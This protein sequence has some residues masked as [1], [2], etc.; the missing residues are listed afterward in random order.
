MAIRSR[1]FVGIAEGIKSHELS[2]KSK[3][4]SLKGT[5]SDLSSRRFGLN[6]EISSLEAE[7]AA[8][9]EDTDE[10]DEPNYALID[11]IESQIASA[12][13]ELSEVEN[14][15][16]DANS[17]LSQS[18]MEL[19]A[20][21]EEKAQ[22]LFE[23]QERARKTSQNI[24]T[25]GGMYG[26]YMGV[27]NTLQNSMQTSL[28]SL[29]QAASILDGSVDGSS[30]GGAGGGQGRTASG[31]G[32][33]MPSDLS[34]SALSAF[35]GGGA[36]SSFSGGSSLSNFST[37]H[38]SG[39]TPASS[40]NFGSSQSVNP[41]KTIN[42][43]SDQTESSYASAAFSESEFIEP[44]SNQASK[45]QSSQESGDLSNPFNPFS[46]WGQSKK[47]TNTTI[48]EFSGLS[49]DKNSLYGD[50]YFVK[51]NNYEAFCEYTK[52]IGQYNQINCNETKSIS[53]KDIEGIYLNDS[54]AHDAHFFWNRG[55]KY[56]MDSESFFMKVASYIPEFQ[57]R[58]NN[59]ESIDSIISN[60]NMRTCYELYFQKPIEVY[61]V[62][63]FYEYAGSG[64]HR[65]MAA[66]KLGI[67]IPV[68]VVARYERKDIASAPPRNIFSDSR[69]YGYIVDK[70]TVSNVTYRPIR[71]NT[72]HRSTADIVSRLSGGD[73]TQGS[74]S[75]LA[76]AYAGNKAGYD[77]LDFRDG[78]SRDFFSSRKSI[79]EI[80]NL[81]NV[82]SSI[83]YGVNDIENARTQLRKI[84]PEKEYYFAI[85][86]HAAIIRKHQDHFE[87]LE[88]QHPST[89]N[90]WHTLDANAL[91]AR[92]GCKRERD[93]ESSSYLIDV[94]T[95][96][97]NKEFLNILGYINTASAEQ[98][99]GGCGSVK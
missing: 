97:N 86:Q 95:L 76:L 98:R 45:Y 66:Q 32:A 20:V 22:T 16:D 59:G 63:G 38:N 71:Q 39:A 1:E 60:P 8:A 62:D 53:A 69:Q 82:S 84:I 42:Y 14:E 65:C 35:S 70:L 34:T 77:V 74:C 10:D 5:V 29:S 43:D 99:K 41:Q 61:E 19:A 96:S 18:E 81:P 75:S 78:A 67:D 44:K 36:D 15:L 40:H 68:R 55:M 51:G 89:G 85:G 33:S 58:L 46:R 12:E 83:V 79:Q 3:I 24:T 31:G 54:E 88:L 87:Y 26:A 90:G 80:A 49:V 94:E 11:A 7:L 91:I 92:F 72:T 23:I 9:Y 48:T 50:R 73:L 52:N 28:A 4:E 37:N 27:G 64:R 21:M 17:E 13:N 2:T 6:R 93:Y 57:S 47:T 25:I 30:S 56:E